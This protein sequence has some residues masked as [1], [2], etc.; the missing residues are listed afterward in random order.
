MAT[1]LEILEA[2]LFLMKQ[3]MKAEPLNIP[4]V[5]SPSP[6]SSSSLSASSSAAS[7]ASSSAASAASPPFTQDEARG[8][9]QHLREFASELDNLQVHLT[10]AIPSGAIVLA[11]AGRRPSGLRIPIEIARHIVHGVRGRDADPET[12][13]E[14]EPEQAPFVHRGPWTKEIFYSHLRYKLGEI[15]LRVAAY[16]SAQ[17]NMV[18]QRLFNEA[19]ARGIVRVQKTNSELNLEILEGKLF[20]KKQKR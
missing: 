1:F 9:M 5:V 8:L 13:A 17:V 12:G 18:V 6:T 4:G 14:A 3:N 19:C 7:A 20:F 11:L 10:A 2:G 15:G 16:K